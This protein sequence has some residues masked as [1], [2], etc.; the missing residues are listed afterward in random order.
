MARFLVRALIAAV[1]LALLGCPVQV[2]TP[3][4][5]RPRPVLPHEIKDADKKP[6]K[7]APK[8]KL[9]SKKKNVR[10]VFAGDT[11]L[12]RGMTRVSD[13]DGNRNPAHMFQ[14]MMPLV[15]DADLFFLNVETV[16]SD[17][18]DGEALQK[19]WRIRAEERFAAGFKAAGV[20]VASVANN[21][22]HDFGAIGIRRT[23]NALGEQ[24]I[25]VTGVEWGP[26][27]GQKPTIVN[28]GP[29][30]VGFLAY[31][32]HGD[33]YR[34]PAWYPRVMPLD[35]KRM[36]AEVEKAA[37]KVDVLVVSMHWG[38]E[39]NHDVYNSSHTDAK[40][41]VAAGADLVIGS[42]PHVAQ[43]V[44]ELERPEGGAK[45]IVAYCLGD[46]VFDKSTP[47]IRQRTDPRFLL[48]VD[49]EGKELKSFELLPMR[50]DMTWRP[51][52][53]EPGDPLKAADW[54]GW[55][56]HEVNVAK[57]V[58]DAEVER[59]V[60]GEKADCDWT[61]D[62]LKWKG[63]YLRWMRAR[64]A[65]EV[66]PAPWHA[67]ATSLETSGTVPRRGVWA[68]PHKD[69][70]TRITF[71]DF[72]LGARLEGFAGVTDWPLAVQ[73]TAQD[74]RMKVQVKGGPSAELTVP[75]AAG[76]LPIALDTSA[77]AGKKADI[78]VE[79]EGGEDRKEPGF[80]FDLYVPD[81][82]KSE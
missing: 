78:V 53:V 58:K 35:R 55:P 6:P 56:E 34:H 82:E 36:L 41:L 15:A 48:A 10:L 1:A 81:A 47:W 37:Q 21:H 43:P 40:K 79:L 9:A 33:E 74:I 69:G 28:V 57:R 71:E 61:A 8:R 16:L 44:I 17:T 32:T 51:Y 50:M 29:I 19:K 42:G 77:L 80:L 3:K 25:R 59:V 38:G 13:R 70:V 18:K 2:K 76:W 5:K 26:N 67:V 64:W 45:A 54:I 65:C 31:N 68:H 39:L 4:K 62:R 7:R 75:H 52:P 66:E 12:A 11:S 14:K 30:S 24:G 60:D 73:K 72:P 49:Y 27:Q 20:D 63:H 22:S 23:L 46:F